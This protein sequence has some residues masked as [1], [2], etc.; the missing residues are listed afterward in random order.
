MMYGERYF[1]ITV[2]NAE[3][4]EVREFSLS[5]AHMTFIKRALQ[6]YKAAPKFLATFFDPR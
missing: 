5:K 4:G 2:H 1:R 6:A 3:S